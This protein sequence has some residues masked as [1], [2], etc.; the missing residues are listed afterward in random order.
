MA[1]PRDTSPALSRLESLLQGIGSPSLG[2]RS[3]TSPR[4][5]L[6][7]IIVA[8]A[9]YGGVMGTFS[10]VG[11]GRAWFILF[12]AVKVPALLLITAAVC[13]PAFFVLHNVLG[14]RDDF[15]RAIRAVL[16]GQAALAAS[17]AS[18][19]PVVRVGYASGMSHGSAQMFNA[20][21]FAIAAL[22]GQIVMLRHY[23]QIA[24]GRNAS[25]RNRHIALLWMWLVAY[26]FVGIQ[27]GWILRPYLGVPGMPATFFREDA[28]TNAYVYFVQL[29]FRR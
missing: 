6:L 28:F 18:L 29:A 23:R 15:P 26:A 20:L 21:L 3:A 14:L 8:G 10:L 1:A 11:E 25:I 16:S 24:A 27:L 22:V 7:L 5:L 12:G 9:I 13:L 19:A 2:V 17:L 4:T